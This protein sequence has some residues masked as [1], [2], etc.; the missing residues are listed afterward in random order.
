MKITKDE[1]KLRIII[2]SDESEKP[3]EPLIL[4]INDGLEVGCAAVELSLAYRQRM[5]EI[6]I[7]RN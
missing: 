7:H 1:E 5:T 4:S 6:L 3:M 2:E